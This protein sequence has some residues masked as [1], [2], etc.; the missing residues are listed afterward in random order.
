MTRDITSIFE[1]YDTDKNS[2][3]HNY[4]EYYQKH[5]P[6]NAYKILEVGVLTGES[7]RCWHEIYPE[8][9]IFGLD[10]F[11]ENPEPFQEHW[12]TWFKGS[13]TDG[14]LLN[15]V[16]LFGPFDIIVE[17]GSHNSRDQLM[18]FYGLVDC[19]KLYVVEDL[20]CAKEEFYRQGMSEYWTLL[21]QIKYDRLFANSYLYND[22]IAFIQ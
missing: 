10:L 22:K 1:K 5:L 7:I 9:H 16:R 17:D 6:D 18:T 15:T 19:C 8:A 20:H 11:E 21:N 12:V 14:K 13:Q 3:G 4:A 2:K